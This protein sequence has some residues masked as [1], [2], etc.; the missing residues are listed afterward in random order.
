VVDKPSTDLADPCACIAMVHHGPGARFPDTAQTVK[1]LKPGCM[2]QMLQP[3]C[4]ELHV[5][6]PQ[7]L[8]TEVLPALSDSDSRLALQ[9]L[10]GAYRRAAAAAPTRPHAWLLYTDTGNGTSTGGRASRW[11]S[12]AVGAAGRM[13]KAPMRVGA[14]LADAAAD[15]AH[16]GARQAPLKA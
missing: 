9:S 7:V 8:K 6:L 10:A 13:A 14:A 1:V 12:S 3:M 5:D 16:F 4:Y 11:V 2:C 15:A